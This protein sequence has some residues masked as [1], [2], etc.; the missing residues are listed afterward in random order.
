MRQANLSTLPKKTGKCSNGGIHTDPHISRGK[1]KYEEITWC[2][3]FLY[4]K[5]RNNRHGIQEESK[6]SLKEMYATVKIQSSFSK[7]PHTT[8]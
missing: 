4:F 8:R 5:E 3:Q 6:E 7:T 1:T 2:S